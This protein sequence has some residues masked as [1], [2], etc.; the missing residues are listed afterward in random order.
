MSFQRNKNT[1][2]I[3]YIVC[4]CVR[5]REREIERETETHTERKR[6][7]DRETHTHTQI[8]YQ[9]MAHTIIEVQMIFIV[10]S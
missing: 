10:P 7:R 4:V 2:S 1:E 3:D 5:E 8:I 6:D 9:E